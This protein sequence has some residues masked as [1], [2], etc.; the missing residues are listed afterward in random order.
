[1]TD[2][3]NR[4]AHNEIIPP[5]LACGLTPDEAI[6]RLADAV[7]KKTGKEMA[8]PRR[9]R[10]GEGL[11]RL[12]AS[13][14][15]AENLMRA[16]RGELPTPEGMALR[17]FVDL[18]GEPL[19][20]R[21]LYLEDLHLKTFV[22]VFQRADTSGELWRVG[23]EGQGR[24]QLIPGNCADAFRQ[25]QEL[26][27][28]W[29]QAEE[30]KLATWLKKQIAAKP[31]PMHALYWWLRL[32][33]HK[34]VRLCNKFNL[35][36]W[37]AHSTYALRTQEGLYLLHASSGRLAARYAYV[38]VQRHLTAPPAPDD[39]LAA[40]KEW[41]S[42][43]RRTNR[44]G[45]WQIGATQ[46]A[47]LANGRLMMTHNDN[48]YDISWLGHIASMRRNGRHFR[49]LEFPATPGWTDHEARIRVLLGWCGV[50]TVTGG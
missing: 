6:A 16:L 3:F 38:L 9:G 17:V 29:A 5:N 39:V 13:H 33:K 26:Y 44:P 8:Q 19:S 34:K 40:I 2:F 47:L 30:E 14:A 42:A 24:S 28:T 37:G 48:R 10:S 23:V 22:P 46:I 31:L 1:M 43:P 15:H 27:I 20:L 41:V 32:D 50:V 7:R 25:A 36:Q 18:I 11:L 35:E 12:S 45:V 21:P 49:Q 4:G